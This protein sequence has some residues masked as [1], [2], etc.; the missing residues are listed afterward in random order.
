MLFAAPGKTDAHKSWFLNLL[1]VEESNEV[2]S[3]K[4]KMNNIDMM[5]DLWNT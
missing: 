3:K 4:I 5:N 2:M 1:F